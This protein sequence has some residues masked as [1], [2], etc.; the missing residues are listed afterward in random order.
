MTTKKCK[1]I[2]EKKNEFCDKKKH[3]AIFIEKKM[4]GARG[5]EEEKNLSTPF[6]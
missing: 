5:K 4:L 1:Y 6:A 2:C 3:D